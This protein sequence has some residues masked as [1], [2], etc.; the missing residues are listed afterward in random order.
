MDTATE[1]KNRHGSFFTIN[2]NTLATERM[3]SVYPTSRG[4]GYLIFESTENII[5]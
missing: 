3:M 4:F 1:K 2:R 5:D